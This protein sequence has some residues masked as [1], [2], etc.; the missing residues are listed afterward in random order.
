MKDDEIRIA[1]S[2]LLGWKMQKEMW[3]TGERITW[4]APYEVPGYLGRYS[5][6][7]FLTDLNAAFS[8]VEF[9]RGKGFTMR[10][11]TGLDGTFEIMVWSHIGRVCIVEGTSL[12]RVICEA[13][14]RAMG[15]WKE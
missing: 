5:P 4:L 14:L 7:E 8:A 3:P 11:D 1:I 2:E 12:A 9:L 10:I 15:G 13:V 6:P